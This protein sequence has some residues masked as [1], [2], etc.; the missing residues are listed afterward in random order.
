MQIEK[1]VKH[2]AILYR[3]AYMDPRLHVPDVLKRYLLF[4]AAEYEEEKTISRLEKSA[5]VVSKLKTARETLQMKL[6]E[7]AMA[8]HRVNNPDVALADLSNESLL[9]IDLTFFPRINEANENIS[10]ISTSQ[11]SGF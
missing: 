7:I 3:K 9:N 8:Y 5:P 2:A 4:K 1:L 11:V 6:R 10:A